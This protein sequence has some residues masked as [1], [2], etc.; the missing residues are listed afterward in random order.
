MSAKGNVWYRRGG[1]LATA[2]VWLSTLVGAGGA[3][4]Q[5]PAMPITYRS[6]HDPGPTFSAEGTYGKGFASISDRDVLGGWLSVEG[7]KLR[8]SAGVAMLMPDGG[9][10]KVAFAAKLGYRISPLLTLF[11]WVGQVGVGYSKVDVP[12]GDLK[13]WDLP[14]GV[15]VGLA[16]LLPFQD[17]SNAEPWIGGSLLLRRTSIATTLVDDSVFRGGVALSLGFNLGFPNGL[18]VHVE[19]QF[20]R[21]RQ[22]FLSEFRGENSLGVGG[23]FRY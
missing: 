9:G 19:G 22:P 1:R 18:G 21:V 16:G 17:V 14:V 3:D 5:L 13:Q 23:F 7:E 20:A 15:A 2:A 10:D 4:A 8:G 12:G 6:V 11:P